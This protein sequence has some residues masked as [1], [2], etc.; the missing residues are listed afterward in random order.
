MTIVEFADMCCPSC[1]KNEPKLKE[2]A[3]TNPK[4]VKIVFREFPLS[5]HKYGKTAAAM[6]E[7]AAEKH[8]FWDFTFSVMD[9]QRQPESIDELL[10]IA[11]SVGLDPDDIRKRL[12][13]PKDAVYDRVA[14]DMNLAHTLKINSTPTFI[15]LAPGQRPDSAGPTEVFD[16]LNG[17]AY[18]SILLGHG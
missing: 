4:T 14:R 10:G 18:K 9:L 8:K 3:T 2:F 13:D 11:R 6:G 5:I 16:K 1:Q 15:I 12:S 17:P 7:Y